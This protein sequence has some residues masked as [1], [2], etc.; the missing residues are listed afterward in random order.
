MVNFISALAEIPIHV[1][2]LILIEAD[3]LH[4]S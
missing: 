2:V 4:Y 1:T 3:K